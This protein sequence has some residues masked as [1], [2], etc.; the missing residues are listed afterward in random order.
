[1][2]KPKKQGPGDG[3]LIARNKKARHEYTLETFFEAG[4]ALEG[5]EVKALR[6]GR[7]QLQ[8]SYV[9]LKHGEAWLLGAH[10]TPLPSVSTHVEPDPRR[11][12]KLLLHRDEID[13]LVGAVER[14]GY[15]L[16]P[17]R[18]YWKHGRAKVEIATARGKKK[19]DKRAAE[20]EREWQR[21][22]E[23]LLKAG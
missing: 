18:L 20:K 23:R 1:M 10:I 6:A 5:W 2:A 12:R 7:A 4:L 16:V 3:N 14:R 15:T 11:T 22:K 9:L 17:T 8:E 19:H 21:Q 13:R